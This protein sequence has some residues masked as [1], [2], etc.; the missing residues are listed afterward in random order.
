MQIENLSEHDGYIN[1]NSRYI[2][3][4]HDGG[5]NIPENCELIDGL[6]RCWHNATWSST[7]SSHE[8]YGAEKRTGWSKTQNSMEQSREYCG[9]EQKILRSR[10]QNTIEQ[11]RKQYGAK[12]RIV[13]SKTVLINGSEQT[14]IL[15]S[16]TVW[17]KE[18]WTVCSR[19][20][21]QPSMEYGAEQR[22]VRSS[23]LQ[24]GA[25]HR[26]VLNKTQNRIE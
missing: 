17:R 4:C 11:N 22:I 20:Q 23:A 3:I 24:Y 18:H 5:I 26:S 10:A 19:K 14:T 1:T 15:E 25:K 9:A 6:I 16:R 12:H 13:W 21:K 8:Q 7:F 2:L